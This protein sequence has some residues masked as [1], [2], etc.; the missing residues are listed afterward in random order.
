MKP[1]ATLIA[2]G[3]NALL[4]PGKGGSIE[5]QFAV[6]RRSMEPIADLAAAGLPLVLTHGNG[7]V[8]GNIL[9]RN[10]AARDQVPPMPLYICDADS[11]G[12]LGFMIAQCLDNALAARGIRRRVAALVTRVEV[13]PRD[14]AFARPSKPIG[15]FYTE[16]EA[17]RMGAERGWV[18]REDAGRGWRR[19]VP[20]PLPKRVVEAAVVAALMR[21]GTVVIAAGGGGVPV[22]AEAEGLRGVDAVIDKDE[23]A[24]CLALALEIPR[25]IILTTVPSVYLDYRKPTQRPI[26]EMDVSRAREYLA[27]G[28]FAPGSMAPKVDAAVR[29][30][31]AGGQE[32]LIT[33][34]ASL[35]QALAG[36]AGTRMVR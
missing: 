26:P 33:D 17:R 15:P 27:A 13:D 20:S 21:E 35:P 11:Q 10:E 3:G 2:I 31:E 1:P 23:T 4:R 7:P 5:E 9:L 18:L 34:A 8:V 6:T 28:H 36:R 16:A 14:P 24:A 12:G 22:V 29:F 32:V 25:L 19:T 30:L